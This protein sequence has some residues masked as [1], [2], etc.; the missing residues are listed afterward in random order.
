LQSDAEMKHVQE[1]AGFLVPYKIS[2][3]AMK[4]ASDMTAIAS[5]II[6]FMFLIVFM[7]QGF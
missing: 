4:D 2:A 3:I 1:T 6:S 5:V 7:A